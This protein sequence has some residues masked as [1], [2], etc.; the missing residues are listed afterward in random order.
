LHLEGLKSFQRAQRLEILE[1]RPM[2]LSGNS[3]L[4][5]KDRYFDPL[6][7]ATWVDEIVLVD[8]NQ[9]LYTL[10]LECRSDQLARFE[11]VFSHFVSTFDF[12]CSSR[13]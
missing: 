6:D 1:K 13:R 11:P 4:F 12:D 3:A 10:E 9:A 8:R 2:D 5:T 7:G